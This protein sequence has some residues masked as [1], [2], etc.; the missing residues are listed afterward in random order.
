MAAYAVT[1][2]LLTGFVVAYQFDA[3]AQEAGSKRPTTGTGSQSAELLARCAQSDAKAFR[4]LYELHSARL[5]GI[6]LRI[7]RNQALA[8]DAV[9]DAMLQV[10]AQCVAL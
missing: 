10:W 3:M 1:S 6:A 2:G 4:K 7:T 5:Y 8:S 9:H